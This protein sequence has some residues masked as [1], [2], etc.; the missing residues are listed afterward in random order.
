MEAEVYGCGVRWVWAMSSLPGGCRDR[1]GVPGED[2][3]VAENAR[4]A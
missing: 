1:G 3:W 2:F 4:G